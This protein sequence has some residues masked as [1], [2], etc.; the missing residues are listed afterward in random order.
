MKR[1]NKPELILLCA[2][3]AI[4][5]F[6]TLKGPILISD[7]ESYLSFT[8]FR[9]PI[10]PLFLAALR[11]VTPS[12]FLG[13]AAFLQTALTLAAATLSCRELQKRFGWST[14]VALPAYLLSILPLFKLPLCPLCQEIGNTIATEGLAYPAFLAFCAIALRS[15]C[16]T[17][18]KRLLILSFAAALCAAIR[19]QL[20]FCYPAVLFVLFAA[21]RNKAIAPLKLGA[22]L[23]AMLLFHGLFSLGHKIYSG[24]APNPFPRQ[25]LLTTILHVCEPEDVALFENS[26][27]SGTIKAVFT[28]IEELQAFSSQRYVFQR[29]LAKQQEQ[30]FNPICWLALHKS[31]DSA[32]NKNLP[33]NERLGKLNESYGRMLS[34]LVPAKKKEL[35]VFYLMM[36]W[37]NS[38]L[39]LLT[40]IAFMLFFMRAYELGKAENR[41]AMMCWLLAFSNLM[42]LILS[43][44]VADRYMLYTRPLFVISFLVL[45]HSW[46]RPGKAA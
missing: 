34:V 40:I 37:Q 3:L 42:L 39:L 38:S 30:S 44:T 19:P 20:L 32:L 6:L 43:A 33:P 17:E 14:A 22:A 12:H 46:K 5:L 8:P 27:D 23:L 1:P 9:T 31:F 35:A 16:E 41:F 15:L 11:F 10:Y 13:L 21:R 28:R 24:F 18:F 25:Q 4:L 26:Q 7:S 29:S 36:L 45:F 2:N